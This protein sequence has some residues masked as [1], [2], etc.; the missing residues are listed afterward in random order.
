MLIAEKVYRRSSIRKA[1]FFGGGPPFY[2]KCTYCEKPLSLLDGDLDHFR[3]KLAVTTAEDEPIFDLDDDGQ[4]RLDAAGRPK[5][6][7]GYY[8]LAYDWRNIL[9]CC[10]ECNQPNRVGS[11]KIG[12]HNRFPVEGRHA[13]SPEEIAAEKPLLI[14]PA[15]G[16]PLDDPE[17]HFRV[18]TERG[19]IAGSTPRG[20]AC[21]EIFGL[22]HRD[23][24]VEERRKAIDQVRYRLIR[25]RF[26]DPRATALLRDIATG[27][28]PYTLV[29]QA[30]MRE[31]GVL[32]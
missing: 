18:D 4:P 11:R 28:R 10:K 20:K 1:F 5:R 7:R 25:M 14:N 8:W 24:L 27:K 13:R 6:H 29:Q 17:L 16:D 19:L 31:A 30:V 26:G 2:G 9:P 21:E 15:S 23:T 3:P 32:S 22:N 12:K